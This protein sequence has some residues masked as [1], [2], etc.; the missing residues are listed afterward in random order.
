MDEKSLQVAHKLFVKDGYNGDISDFKTL[1]STNPKALDVSHKLFVKDG[2]NGDISDFKTLLG[3]GE[4]ESIA[5]PEVKKKGR[6]MGLPSTGGS[7]D[8]EKP[9]DE[10]WRRQ[11]PPTISSGHENY[12]RTVEDEQVLDTPSKKLSAPPFDPFKGKLVRPTEKGG[13]DVAKAPSYEDESKKLFK[14]PKE[15][16]AEIT[17]TEDIGKKL[18]QIT[19]ELMSQR[20]EN[21]VPYL[22][23][24][25]KGNGVTF[26]KTGISGDYVTVTTPEGKRDFP[27]DIFFDSKK[28]KTAEELK[29]YIKTS[30]NYVKDPIIRV[31]KEVDKYNNQI[32]N[33]KNYIGAITNINIEANNIEKN[34]YDYIKTSKN[35]DDLTRMYNSYPEDQR[36]TPEV[37]SL[38]D[39]I[40]RVYD[41]LKGQKEVLDKSIPLYKAHKKDLDYNVGKYVG[42]LEDKGTYGDM[43]LQGV[44]K[45][46]GSIPSGIV[47]TLTDV[48]LMSNPYLTD[49]V[50]KTIKKEIRSVTD[51]LLRDGWSNLLKSEDS[52]TEQYI[53]SDKRSYLS[54]AS[55]G[56]AT[57]SLSML[58]GA[59]IRAISM[60]SQIYDGM[61]KEIEDDPELS[62][63]PENDK[64]ALK[65]ITGGI[66]SALEKAGFRNAIESKGLLNNLALKV[67]GQY[68]P[69]A[70]IQAVSSKELIDNVVKGEIQKGALKLVGGF[71]AEAETGVAQEIADITIKQVY[72]DMQDKQLFTTPETIGEYMSQVGKAGFLEGLG[73][74]VI[75]G[76]STVGS[77]YKAGAFKDLSDN[78]LKVFGLTAN[79]EKIQKA[80]VADLKLKVNLGELSLDEAKQ[81]LVNYQKAEQLFNQIPPGLSL[82]QTKESLDLLKQKQELTEKI[83]DKDPSLVKPYKDQIDAIDEKLTNIT[84]N[85]IQEQTTSE[86]MLRNEQPEMGLQGMGEGD[87]QLQETTTGTK[88]VLTDEEQ[89]RKVILEEAL[90]SPDTTTG[91]VTIGDIAV[92]IAEAQKELD[93]LA[94]TTQ[95]VKPL[96]ETTDESKTKNQ[97]KTDEAQVLEPIEFSKQIE[98]EYGVI[99]DLTGNSDKGDLTLSRIEVPKDERSTGVGSKAMEAIIKYADSIGRRIVLTPSIDFGG[100][101]VNRLKEF[102]KKFGFVENKG[103]NKDFSTKDSMYRQPQTPVDSGISITNAEKINALKAKGSELHSSII[104]KAQKAIKTLKSVLPNFDIVIHD[105]EESYNTAVEKVNGEKGSAGN[106]SYTKQSDGSFSGSIDINLNKANKLTVAHEVAHGIMLK[107][108]GENEQIFKTFVDKMQ[109][110]L[111]S[112]ANKYL[113]DFA[114][115]YKGDVKYEEYIVELAAILEQEYVNISPTILQKIAAV[116]NQTVSKITG[117]KITVFEDTK[118]TKELIDFLN[119]VSKSIRQGE[120]INGDYLK[121]LN[122]GGEIGI[123]NF[124]SKSSKDTKKAPSVSDD[125]RSF[126][127]N[128]VEDIDIKEFNGMPFVTN[129]YD[130]TT[131]GETD[132]GN[133]FKINMLGGKN[134]VPYMMSL[135]NKKLGDV[136]N[137]AAFNS[138]AQAESFIRNAKEGKASLFAPHSGTLSN[139]WQFQQH[140]FAELINLI[141][142]KGIMSESELIDTFNK[143]IESNSENKAAFKAFKDKYGKNIKNFSSFKSN[144]KKIV[145]LLDIK[146]NYSPDLRK[147][148]NNAIAANKIFQKAIGV[149]NKEEFFNRIM[150][151]L[152]KGVEGGEIINVIKFDP[153]TFKIVETKPDAVDHHPSF[154]WS[155]LAKINGIYQPTDF[156]KSSNVTESYI[157]YNKSGSETSRKAQEPKFEQ[158]NVASSAGAIPKVAV[159]EVTNAVS[160]SQL[161]TKSD[162]F[163]DKMDVVFPNDHLGGGYAATDENGNLLGRIKMTQIDD[164]TVKIDEIV[165]KNKGERTSNGSKIMNI[166]TKVADENNVKMI[167][168]PNLI[169]EIKAKGFETPQKLKEF[170]SKFGFEKSTKNNM[171]ERNP[172]VS[173]SQVSTEG[174]Y[175]EIKDTFF[176][177]LDANKNRLFF[178]DLSSVA[179]MR[180]DSRSDVA[181]MFDG[182]TF[183]L[184]ESNDGY[185]TIDDFQVNPDKLG[186]GR[187]SESLKTLT[188]FADKNNITLIGEP[189]AQSERRAGTKKGLNQK[190]LNE[191]YKKNGFTKISKDTLSKNR[192]AENNFFERVPVVSDK[193]QSEVDKMNK[194][195]PISKSQKDFDAFADRFKMDKN[196]YIDKII[197]GPRITQELNK[198]GLGYKAIKTLPNIYGTGGS[199]Y[200]VNK[201]GSRVKRSTIKSKSQKGLINLTENDVLKY[202]RVGIQDKRTAQAMNQIG[203]S[204]VKFTKE[205]VGKKIS[206][207]FNKLIKDINKYIINED[208][209]AI[210]QA[211][212]AEITTLEDEG[213]S[214]SRIESARSALDENSPMRANYIKEYA[215]AQSETLSQWKDYLNQSDYSDAFKYII[216]DAVLTHN[217]DFKT[218]SYTKRSNK[219]IRNFT[220]FDAGTL[221]SI[222][223][224]ESKALLKDYVE[225]QANNVNNIVGANSM[226]STKEGKWLKFDGGNNAQDLSNT[227]NKLSQLVQNTYW[228]TKTNALNQLKGGD[229]YVYVTDDEK[230]EY[231]P[232]I[233]VRMDGDKVGEVRGNASSKQD[234]EP[235]MLPVADKFLKESIPNDSGKKW[236]DSIAYNNKVKDF[237][238]NIEDKDMSMDDILEYFD[239]IKDAKKYSVDY[240]ENGLVSK[241]TE[242]IKVKVRYGDVAE[243]LRGKIALY[244]SGI[245]SNTEILINDYYDS[246]SVVFPKNLKYISGN[247]DFERSKV[248]SLGNLQSIGGTADFGRSKI[249]S[250]GNLQS[251]GGTANFT[252]SIVKD[253][254]NLQSIGGYATF[255]GS[256]VKDLGNLQSIGGYANFEGSKVESLGNLQSI[257]GYAEFNDSIVKDLGNLQ[258]IGG[259][260]TFE[261]SKVESLGN[262]QSIGGNAYFE[263]SKVESLGNLQSIGGYAEFN[264]SIVKDL[265]NLQSIGGNAYFEGSKVES[266]GNLQS[267]GGNADFGRSKI[268][269]LGNL[270]SIG[271]QFYSDSP[272]LNEQALDIKEKNSQATPQPVSKSQKGQDIKDLASKIRSKKLSGLGVHVD[273]GI[274]K[275]IY[276]GALEIAAR[277]VEK[278]SKLGNAINKAIQWIDSKINNAKWNKGLFAK[279]LN[280]KY[281]VTLNGK[282]VEVEVDNSKPTA[283]LINGFYSPLE[284]GINKSKLDKATGKEWLKRLIG[285]TEGDELKWTG[286]ADYLT[287]NSDKV[288]YK[289][290]LLD[291]FKT[292]R[293]EI[294]EVV[295]EEPT[296]DDIDTLMNDEVGEDMSR[297]DAIEY[298]RNDYVE[299]SRTKF[300]QYQ[301]EGQKENYK[302]IL[303]TLPSK[304]KPLLLRDWYEGNMSKYRGQEGIKAPKFADLTDK[305]FNKVYEEF[306]RSEKE[307]IAANRKAQTSF[308]SSHFDEPNILVH[309]RMNTRTD[310]EGNKVLF[311]EEVQ[312]DWG[313]KGKKEGFKDTSEQESIINKSKEKISEYNK[314][315]KKLGLLPNSST[316]EIAEF[317][318]GKTERT[319]EINKA[320]ARLEKYK[321]TV[322]NNRDW[323]AANKEIEKYETEKITI[324][325]EILSAFNGIEIENE[326]INIAERSIDNA[327][328]STPQAPFVMDTNAWAKLGLKVALKEAVKQGADKIAWTTGEQQNDRYDLSKQVDEI[329]YSKLDNGKYIISADKNNQSISS[330]VYSESQLEGVLGKE[331]SNKIINNE[332]NVSEE[333]HSVIGNDYYSGQPREHKVLKGDY[334]KIGGKGMKGFY[335]SPK[336]G[337]LGIVGNVA[338]S[339]FK[340]EPKTTEIIKKIYDGNQQEIRFFQDFLENAGEGIYNV[341]AVKL[342]INENSDLYKEFKK[343]KLK[344]KSNNITTTQN[345]IDITP[346]LKESVESGIPLFKG[347]NQPV[348]KSQKGDLSESNLPGYDAMIK[349]LDKIID[350]TSNKIDSTKKRVYTSALAYLQSSLVYENATDVQR[351]ALVRMLNKKLGVREKSAPSPGKLFDTIKDIKNITMTDTQLLKQRIRDMAKSSRDTKAAW[352]KISAEVIKSVRALKINGKIS[353]SQLT[354]ILNKFSKINMFNDDSI[355]TFLDYMSNV[356]KDVDYQN[357][358]IAAN[359]IKKQIAKLAANKSKNADLRALAKKFLELDT[360]LV[361]DIDRYNSIATQLKESITGTKSSDNFVDII[362]IVP[363]LK[364]IETVKKI[365]DRILFNRASEQLEELFG[366]DDTSGMTYN[367][368]IK[369]IK[370]D[371][372]IIKKEDEGLFRKKAKGRFDSFSAIINKIISTGTEPI[373]GDIF[374]L[375]ASEEQTIKK[376]MSMDLSLLD[377]KTVIDAVDALQNFIQ[378]KSIAKIGSVFYEYTGLKN[379]LELEKNKLI[380]SKIKLYFSGVIGGAAYEQLSSL[381]SLIEKMF[382]GVIRGGIFEDK[383]GISSVVN[384]KAEATSEVKKFAVEYTKEFGDTKPN[385]KDFFDEENI[386]ER[387]M[388]AH[389]L[390]T[391]IGTN[392]QMEDDFIRSKN[393]I[394]DSIEYLT[395]DKSSEE[396]NRLGELY[397]KVYNKILKDAESIE[398]IEGKVSS[399]NGE[400]VLFW[401]NKWD[402]KFDE[403]NDVSKSIYNEILERESN[404]TPARYL[405]TELKKE[406]DIEQTQSVFNTNNFRPGTLYK[407]ESGSLKKAQ[408]KPLPK[409]S[410]INLSFDTNNVNSMYDALIDIKTAGPIR[411]LQAFMENMSNIIPNK[412]DRNLL[413]SRVNHYVKLT[414]NKNNINNE[415][416]SRAINKLNSITSI[417]VASALTSLSQPVKQVVPLAFNTI[418]NANGLDIRNIWNK[419]IRDFIDN[420]G[421]TVANRSMAS[422]AQITKS[423]KLEDLINNSSGI[424]QLEYIKKLG[425]FQLKWL[426]EKPDVFI[427]RASWFTYYKDYLSK[428]KIKFDFNV[429]NEDAKNYATR[430]VNRQQNISDPDLGG[431]LF[432]K[433]DAYRTIVVKTIFAFAN[434]R[435]NQSIRLINDVTTL[436][437]FTSSKQDKA[438]AAKSLAGFAV[439]AAAFRLVSIGTTALLDSI[440]NSIWGGD[441]DEEEKQKRLNNIYKG[442]ITNLAAD[443]L[444]PVPLTDP[445]VTFGINYIAN[446]LQMDKPEKERL[447]LF[448][449]KPKDFVKQAGI[450]GIAAEDA[451]G[452]YKLSKMIYTK[453]FVDDYG[454]TKTLSDEDVN[455]LPLLLLL[456]SVSMLKLVPTDVKTISKRELAIIKKQGKTEKQL[457][458]KTSSKSSSIEDIDKEIYKEIENIDKEI[459]DAINENF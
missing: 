8:S 458:K 296:E 401:V 277:E 74:F 67:I 45:S 162:N 107:V 181:M 248:E 135:K 194:E 166:V 111:N 105:T 174:K 347:L 7:L 21:A 173:K 101:S 61:T 370:E 121:E 351:E 345:S 344:S 312:S 424:K 178:T 423:N 398:D 128:L 352:L 367:Q 160:K 225:V 124:G 361:E 254:G 266:L 395:N 365:Q 179:Q 76:V 406:L 325:K 25:F 359:K 452:L 264:D 208:S 229:F 28:T 326:K 268:E 226:V 185:V 48:V 210:T 38:Y 425:E 309:L 112:T 175:E 317:K 144:P 265:G 358:L 24:L 459:D 336:E 22:N 245:E 193:V 187:G 328:A 79:N 260:A 392:E 236:L 152:N 275:T 129:M 250:L 103:K 92:P 223:D 145:E 202:N 113:V 120:E 195:F 337:S 383:S 213:A 451:M 318:Q 60:F 95:Q 416:L 258:S 412:N 118:N 356:F 348:S 334:L 376:F 362:D 39:E 368:I 214:L 357:K 272:T 116:I 409:G 140:T 216:L 329:L 85:A 130:Y 302:E 220:P 434:F 1:V 198:L 153:N 292:N 300:S 222:Y 369:L 411:Q 190:Q 20:E 68:K 51:P 168:T 138:Q 200:I 26:E 197:E 290:D 55:Y 163:F 433:N 146:N 108:F 449:A 442:Q 58:G 283:E 31:Q 308:Q 324:R 310:V 46:A 443:M 332:G 127:K 207:E 385:G 134:Y 154:G 16:Q 247:A 448:E 281:K 142:D 350:E 37:K 32:L 52:S 315:L 158:K 307:R 149:K 381:P 90:Q 340:Q 271:G 10:S 284:R 109:P 327:N 429:Y 421:T 261:G 380:S 415:Q 122:S 444:S 106:F 15:K 171:M 231:V 221:A 295:K 420:S 422:E 428:N 215:R 104:N 44:A 40:T 404:Y 83:K 375:T 201:Y 86:S 78:T 53:S 323:D 14:A 447:L 167:L 84:K 393:D 377:L 342:E 279:H 280:D 177:G 211:I 219:T 363:T 320:I 346:E 71:L 176:G 255:N 5:T 182:A 192:A 257:G 278:G 64:L 148:L 418:I 410:Y 436:T 123:F 80:Y 402:S 306:N 41:N 321:D 319:S 224:S 241:L 382:K 400:A 189:L 298:L 270:Q 386:V 49:E 136:S 117:G 183:W 354:A 131:V 98:N 291:Y 34:K 237:T 405:N 244:S 456:N 389:M 408:H 366:I 263:G 119:T 217:Y 205:E 238:K 169:G 180:G 18:E 12:G 364:Y 243:D 273:F 2:Y 450:L 282:E 333:Y 288:I 57:S 426:L 240:G 454:N 172:V 96:N 23:Y 396:E 137:L 73:G 246:S 11:L 93:A 110:I 27:L 297:D 62:K 6:I 43:L 218:G 232:R 227:A 161:A 360:S 259:Y 133:G 438:I 343:L 94:Q 155:L 33:E 403:M 390:R 413:K 59:P 102:Y 457:T 294:V 252:N 196:G 285:E 387:G 72:N 170:Y 75:T 355:N 373:S 19:P 427:A 445:A 305:E 139:S 4:P 379:S 330:G 126:I 9:E 253:L 391:I 430:M 230:G 99:V 206:E 242:N 407:E 212:K 114:N 63:I 66:G 115:N 338:K 13:I 87:T 188:N 417:G 159:F 371:K 374:E 157:K 150:D 378:N 29:D 56:L 165:S 249:E 384:G 36:N 303:V 186:Q 156:Y 35:Y 199:H 322:R 204:G 435:I 100:T 267:I 299:N 432:T 77:A 256:I 372:L 164:N 269:S 453:Q 88:K 132:L 47:N 91:T 81:E 141:T 399:I 414:R 287:E 235:D 143:T 314:S 97:T 349:K 439:E 289:N 228:C 3:I 293:I 191:F 50:K 65:V 388:Y 82:D 446:M 339:L 440:T 147:A 301:L 239:I 276:N 274:S 331:I 286:V 251:I 397:K 69:G 151:P 54:Q 234:L 441:D 341:D 42:M 335:G 394:I 184:S 17:Q 431:M 437:S 262:L 209:P 353:T 311:L 316:S 30:T 455:K 70:A 125:S 304:E 313:Q 233:A 419:Q 89:K 203:L